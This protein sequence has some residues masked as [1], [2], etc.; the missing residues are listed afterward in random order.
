M[1]AAQATDP[2]R[3]S[4]LIDTRVRYLRAV[5]RAFLAEVEELRADGHL[6]FGRD[7]NLREEVRRLEI[8]LIK[9]ALQQTGGHQGRAAELLGMKA[10]TLNSK[11]KL[12][13]LRTQIFRRV[14]DY[15]SAMVDISTR[16]RPM[17]ESDAIA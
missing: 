11:L 12:Y 5:V 8:D 6:E 16:Q 7:L 14:A 9:Y 10:T 1:A 17:L 15:G 4:R 13:G 2:L 3:A